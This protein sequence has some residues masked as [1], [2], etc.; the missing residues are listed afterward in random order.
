MKLSSL[1]PPI[2]VLVPTE[3]NASSNTLITKSC[4]DVQIMLGSEWYRVLRGEG[5][6]K[7]WAAGYSA[8]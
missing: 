7:D 2:C 1:P 4:C 6:K 3:M 5:G 8:G